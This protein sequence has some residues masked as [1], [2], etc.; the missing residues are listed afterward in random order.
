MV[1]IPDQDRLA[2]VDA[3]LAHWAEAD[4]INGTPIEIV[5]GFGVTELTTLRDDYHVKQSAIATMEMQL[6]TARAERDSA[7][8]INP[9]QGIWARLKQYK[10]L[11]KARLGG[12]HPLTRTV[13]NLGKVA[14]QNYH[15]IVHAFIDHWTEVNAAVTPAF[16][17]GTYTL[18]MLQADHTALNAKMQSV[19]QLENARLP[20]AREEREQLFGDEPEEVREE[21]S[22]VSRLVLYQATIR[23]IF[24]TQPIAD[25]L[26]RI[27]P[28][29]PT[30]TPPLPEVRFNAQQV[31]D[32]VETWHEVP[33]DVTNS[34][35]A[36]L[37]EGAIER[38]EEL[39]SPAPG[40]IELINWPGL[41]LVDELDE[42]ELR[43]ADNL[44]VARGV[45]DP[46]LPRP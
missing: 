40:S 42:F 32:I 1:R 25:S 5:T 33:E 22:I 23:A 8:G 27:F 9:N 4:T 16:T 31:S 26:P 6:T 46:S 12:R 35:L 24:P 3:H 21:S 41:F 45:L 13:P 19:E 29:S 44:T 7:W 17:L 34:Q 20:L 38:T 28:G 18:A 10:P 14:V 15:K 43:S 37:R 2:V 30:P 36:F 39:T 11:L